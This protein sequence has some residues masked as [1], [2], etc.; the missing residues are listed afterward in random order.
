MKVCS[1]LQRQPLGVKNSGI[2]RPAAS[3]HLPIPTSSL[4]RKRAASEQ[5][6]DG[7]E[8]CAC[9]G[10]R[11]NVMCYLDNTTENMSNIL[12]CCLGY[13]QDST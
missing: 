1:P 13:N 6:P 9:V 10:V 7:K 4:L 8:V 12:V 5:L 2:P 11:C 3:S